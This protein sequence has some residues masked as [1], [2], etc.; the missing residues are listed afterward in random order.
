[1]FWGELQ[2]KIILYYRWPKSLYI[3][4]PYLNGFIS[5]KT[6]YRCIH[7]NSS[8]L[9]ECGYRKHYDVLHGTSPFADY[10]AVNGWTA[11]SFYDGNSD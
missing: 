4:F 2:T 6:S 11:N 9:K 3:K 10:S 5:L 1:M 7:A 8:K